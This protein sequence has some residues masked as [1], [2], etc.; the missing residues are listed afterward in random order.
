MINSFVMGIKPGGKH[1]M[2]KDFLYTPTNMGGL[3]IIRLEDFTKAIKC[4]WVKRYCIDKLDDHWA[5]LLDTHFNITP[6]K[7]HTILDFGPEKLNKI[8]NLKI[9]GLSS[10]FSAY[11]SLKSN[12]PTCPSTL[13]NSWL[14]QPLFYNN[15]FT[16]KVPNS[17]KDTFLTPTFYGLPDSAHTLTLKDFF[18]NGKFI[19]KENLNTVAQ[20][21]LMQMQ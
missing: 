14:C 11:K 9:P 12:F 10:I 17:K 21:K 2:S 6:S 8:I 1:W 5:D 15:N 3:G 20:A 19:E 7:R 13:D 16:R 18:P 4:S